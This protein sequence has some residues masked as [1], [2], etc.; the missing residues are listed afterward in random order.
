MQFSTIITCANRQDVNISNK[1]AKCPFILNKK[2]KKCA[3]IAH[4]ATIAYNKRLPRAEMVNFDVVIRRFICC[5]LC[6][7]QHV[8]C[9]REMTSL[10]LKP[11]GVQFA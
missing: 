3:Y 4:L 11:F 1:K 10:F 6:G 5:D 7:I 9:S 8:K 2:A